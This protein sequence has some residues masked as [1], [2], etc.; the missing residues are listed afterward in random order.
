MSFLDGSC[1]WYLF[2]EGIG[3]VDVGSCRIVQKYSLVRQIICHSLV[4]DALGVIYHG[5]QVEPCNIRG[6]WVSVICILNQ[7][8]SDFEDYLLV[9]TSV[10]RSKYGTQCYKM[11]YWINIPKKWYGTKVPVVAHPFTAG[12]LAYMISKKAVYPHRPY[13]ILLKS[14]SWI[15]YFQLWGRL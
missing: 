3:L 11:L 10:Y 9:A 2:M 13:S 7:S 4:H 5:C 15:L 1:G 8:P 6:M 12:S 14:L